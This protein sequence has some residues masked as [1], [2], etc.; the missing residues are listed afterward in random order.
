MS[1]SFVCA[2]A[3]ADE[4]NRQAPS[5]VERMTLILG[6]FD[7]PQC[8][9]LLEEIADRSGLPRSTTHRIL[10]QLVQVGWLTHS[11]AGYALGPRSLG[12]G[13]REFGH[14]LLRAVAVPILH[15]LAIHTGLV[16]H[17]AVLDAADI[18]YLDKLGGREAWCV[19][20]AVGCR[21][22]AHCTAVGKAMLACK[23]PEDVDLLYPV[24]PQP[25]NERSVASLGGLH[26]ELALIRSRHGLATDRGEFVRT[27]SCVAA[28]VGGPDGA[29][30]AISVVGEEWMQVQRTAP[31]ARTA[32]RAITRELSALR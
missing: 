13:G 30:A 19:P 14:S 29:V 2:S 24:A 22:P 28:P 20:S 9:L 16:V 17:L 11:R 31:V 27:V 21:A 5:M 15:Q 32:A 6:A 26:R 3:S 8:R 7:D 12:L 1:V 23:P 4:R 18:Y 25:R 10:D